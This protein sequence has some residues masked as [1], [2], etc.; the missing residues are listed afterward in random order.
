VSAAVASTVDEQLAWEARSRRRAAAAAAGAGVLTLA[1][2]VISSIALRDLPRVTLVE[3]MRNALDHG[4]QT[5]VGLKASQVVYLSDHA[6]SLIISA[7]ALALGA[8][9]LGL[10][11]VFLYR[12]TK[13]R[14]P[15]TPAPS[16]I[17]A[18]LG[19]GFV[20]VG[21]VVQ[22]IVL[23]SKSHD[24]ANAT[25]HSRSAVND[26]VQSPWVLG[27]STIQFLGTALLGVALIIIVLNAMRAG[28]LTR[29]MGVLGMIVGALTIFP[30]L[31]PLPV[32]PTFWL[33][34]LGVLIAGRWPNGMPPAWESGQ[35]EPWPTTRELREAA[36]E[37]AGD[38]APAPSPRAAAAQDDDSEGYDG[39]DAAESATGRP[40]SS[41]KKRKRKRRT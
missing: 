8:L 30:R 20:A 18:A 9:A 22:Q 7:V 6:V 5:K 4:G 40:H 28:L 37:A 2:Q 32:V 1:G 25:D 24:F 17:M 14:R 34:A 27:G 29:F 16:R 3:G 11:L 19:A 26:V 35:A 15:E 41:S 39:E 31:S 36:A 33:V 12:A 21:Q 13:F 23:A 10:T 38:D